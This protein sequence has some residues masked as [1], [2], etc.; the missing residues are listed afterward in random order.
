MPRLIPISTS[1]ANRTAIG[2]DMAARS[3]PA[4]TISV[5]SSQ[6]SSSGISSR[7]MIQ[8]RGVMPLQSAVGDGSW[9]EGWSERFCVRDMVLLMS[10][11]VSYLMFRE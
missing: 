4:A 7:P 1:R 9:A 11:W 8:A 2:R 5:Y 6:K 3:G 10:L